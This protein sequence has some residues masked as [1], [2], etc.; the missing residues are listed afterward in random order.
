MAA[1]YFALFET[2][3]GR[4]GIVWSQRGIVAMQLPERS[5]A[6]T[7]A[8]MRERFGEALESKPT[9]MALRAI[10]Q[11]GALLAGR[12]AELST[13]ELDFEGIPEFSRQVYELTRRI[14][15][16]STVSYG[17]I[18]T[19]LGSPHAARAVGQALGR[20]PWALIVPCHRVLA[21]SGKLTGFSAPGGLATK[22][23]Q[24]NASQVIRHL[25]SGDELPIITRKPST[26]VV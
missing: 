16:G 20:N 19:R 18:A 23:I 10:E 1:S 9:G 24:F 3:V 11:V 12:Q 17:D 4:C 25:A 22:P 14:P 8:R 2:P 7:R 5:V 15:V 21:A 26:R 6:A 13:I